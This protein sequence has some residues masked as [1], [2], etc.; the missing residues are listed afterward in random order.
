MTT[1]TLKR[2]KEIEASLEDINHSRRTVEAT[3][4]SWKVGAWRMPPDLRDIGAKAILAELD[5]RVATLQ[6][7]LESL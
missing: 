2:A 7:D 1:E 6:A 3:D 4:F 5:A